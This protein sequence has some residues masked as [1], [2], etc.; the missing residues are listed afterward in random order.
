MPGFTMPGFQNFNLRGDRIAFNLKPGLVSES[1][2]YPTYVKITE[3]LY[4]AR[5]DCATAI[6]VLTNKMSSNNEAWNVQ[7][8][9][10]HFLGVVSR[11]NVPVSMYHLG[12][13]KRHFFFW[14]AN[15]S[16]NIPKYTPQ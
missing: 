16:A 11:D 7:N 2:A 12:G 5:V 10:P 15:S 3:D 1:L 8:K 6:V 13:W 4:R 14:F 9:L